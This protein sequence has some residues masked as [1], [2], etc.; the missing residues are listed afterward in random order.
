[1][2]DCRAV[3]GNVAK[4]KWNQD[5]PS[6]LRRPGP[7]RGKGVSP[8][9][10]FLAGTSFLACSRRRGARTTIGRRPTGAAPVGSGPS[11]ASAHRRLFAVL[12]GGAIRRQP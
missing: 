10:V 6:D 11:M 3:Q 5:L 1:M 12:G 2:R 7:H 9:G 4:A 8:A